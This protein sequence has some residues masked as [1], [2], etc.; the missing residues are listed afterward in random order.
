MYNIYFTKKC[1]LNIKPAI[2]VRYTYKPA[3]NLT[4]ATQQPTHFEAFCMYLIN[5]HSR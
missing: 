4:S 1:A 3:S 5:M 2:S